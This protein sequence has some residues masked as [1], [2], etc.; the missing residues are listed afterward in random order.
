M[1]SAVLHSSKAFFNIILSCILTAPWTTI[2]I[3]VR[4]RWYAQFIQHLSNETYTSSLH[5]VW[6]KGNDSI[7]SVIMT[8]LH[9]FS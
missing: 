4:F 7:L 5:R 3:Q 8:N 6:N 9:N 2:N 1:E